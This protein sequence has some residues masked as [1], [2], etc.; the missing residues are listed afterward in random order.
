MFISL[1]FSIIFL[2]G[3]HSFP[4]F[5]VVFFWPCFK[6]QDSF[7]GFHRIC[8]P[9]IFILTKLYR[10]TNNRQVLWRRVQYVWMYV[11][12][13]VNDMM[14][15]FAAMAG[16][17]RCFFFTYSFIHVL[18]G[19]KE[20]ATSDMHSGDENCAFYHEYLR[21]KFSVFSAILVVF[22]FFP[23]VLFCKALLKRVCLCFIHVF[24][25]WQRYILLVSKLD[26]IFI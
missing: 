26:A 16:V 14:P 21:Y 9:F 1:L 13:A 22:F 3:F 25:F 19:P 8:K 5:V 10:E 20:I 17:F 11:Q 15:K 4:F 18:L 24:L 23:I 12:N 6:M 7:S 2:W